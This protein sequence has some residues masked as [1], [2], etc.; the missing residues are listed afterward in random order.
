MPI[1]HIKVRVIKLEQLNLKKNML[2]HVYRINKHDRCRSTRSASPSSSSSS[3]SPQVPQASQPP[4]QLPVPL[5]Q[6][7]S[8]QPIQHMPKLHW[9]LF[10]PEYA[11]KPEKDEE[12]HLLNMSDWMDT[13]A[14]PEGVKVQCFCLTVVEEA[15]LWYKSLRPINVDWIGLQN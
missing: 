6:P 2:S 10:K 14:F 15:R 9:S 8:T 12:A 11:G 3:S 13:H 1:T 7:I 5:N 4:I